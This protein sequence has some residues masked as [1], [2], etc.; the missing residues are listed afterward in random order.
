MEQ[1]ELLDGYIQSSSSRFLALEI[2][3]YLMETL[4]ILKKQFLDFFA[5]SKGII[6]NARFK[7]LEQNLNPNDKF[8]ERPEILPNDN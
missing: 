5:D 6:L 2:I 4:I 3:D 8:V 7:Q 1:L